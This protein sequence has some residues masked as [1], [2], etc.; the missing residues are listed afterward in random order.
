MRDVDS[1]SDV[2][3]RRRAANGYH[4]ENDMLRFAADRPA[5]RSWFLTERAGGVSPP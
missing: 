1:L 5:E 2:V 4:F 3:A